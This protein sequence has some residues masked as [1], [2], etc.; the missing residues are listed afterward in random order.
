[1]R[2]GRGRHRGRSEGVRKRKKRGEKPAYKVLCCLL[3][4]M[5]IFL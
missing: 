5:F 1:M 4:E 2:G 3:V